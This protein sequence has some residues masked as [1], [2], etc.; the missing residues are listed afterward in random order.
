MGALAP[1]VRN[2]LTCKQ[3]HFVSELQLQD[4]RETLIKFSLLTPDDLKVRPSAGS[5]GM[6]EAMPFQSFS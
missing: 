3:S 1:E 2:R 4:A 5:D 6:A